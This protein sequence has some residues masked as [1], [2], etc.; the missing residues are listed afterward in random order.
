MFYTYIHFRKDDLKP[1]YIG[2]GQGRRH[3]VKTKR[4]NH[5]NNVVR[6]HGFTSEIICHWETEKEALEHE[7][8]LIQCFKDMKI[9]LVNMTDG[10]E[11]TS[12]WI[13]NDSWKV[14][15]SESQKTKFAKGENPLISD[16]AKQKRSKT[17]VGR[18]L[19]KEHK[20]KISKSLIGNKRTLGKTLTEEHKNKISKSLIGNKRNLGKK[21]PEYIK[22]KISNSLKGK[23]ISPDVVA[24]QVAGRKLTRERKLQQL[25]KED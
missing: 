21:M 15:K 12:G 20:Q 9:H 5:W 18:K 10:G 16:A 11:G 24:K 6:K 23:I 4:N 1:F 3:L 22:E 17:I 2:K 14:K 25:Q 19:D 13:P 7:M 8:F